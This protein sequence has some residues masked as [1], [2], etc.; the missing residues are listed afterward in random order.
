MGKGGKVDGLP[1]PM[2]SC[3][4][5]AGFNC[6]APKGVIGSLGTI[7]STIDRQGRACEAAINDANRW[8]DRADAMDPT[9]IVGVRSTGPITPH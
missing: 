3:S 8:A 9:L 6:E 4:Q 5:R 7:W 1:L 2:K